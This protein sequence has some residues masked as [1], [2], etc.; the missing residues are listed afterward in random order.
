MTENPFALALSFAP[1]GEQIRP[2]Q[3]QVVSLNFVV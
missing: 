1:A 2:Q 3:Y